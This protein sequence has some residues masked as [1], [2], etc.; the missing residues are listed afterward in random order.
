M[1]QAAHCWHVPGGLAGGWRRWE[2]E[3]HGETEAICPLVTAGAAAIQ[4]AV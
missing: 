3:M 1:R 2:R 4:E